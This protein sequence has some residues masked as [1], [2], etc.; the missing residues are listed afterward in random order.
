MDEMKRMNGIPRSETIRRAVDRIPVPPLAEGFTACTMECLHRAERR[1]QRLGRP[2]MV[3]Y[4]LLGV[5]A[6]AALSGWIYTQLT[7]RSPIQGL[8]AWWKGVTSGWTLP[9][10]EWPTF[11]LPQA[12]LSMPQVELPAPS[13][14]AAA[15]WKLAGFLA[16][17]GL[18]LLIADLLIRRRI[19]SQRK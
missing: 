13:P 1:R 7:G 19:A 2:L 14:E 17:A 10:F 3:G 16:V 9:A 4:G 18:V 8:A 11:D 15:Q 6:L 5:G 12:G